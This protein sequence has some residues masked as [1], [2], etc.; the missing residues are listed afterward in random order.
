MKVKTKVWE[1]VDWKAVTWFVSL[2]LVVAIVPRFIHNQFIT[3]PLVNAALIIGVVTLGT[4]PA[5]TIGLV[6][7]VIA[8]SSGLLPAPLAPMVPFIMISNAILIVVFNYTRK[9]HFGAGA[10]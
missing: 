2:V 5:V 4:G 6:P 3:G 10:I 9:I 7:S 1:N 8:L